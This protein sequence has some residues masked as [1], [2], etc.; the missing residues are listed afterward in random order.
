MKSLDRK[1]FPFFLLIPSLAY[2]WGSNIN[3]VA[4]QTVVVTSATGGAIAT[5]SGGGNAKISSHSGTPRTNSSGTGT[6]DTSRCSTGCF[7]N[8]AVMT[9]TV[10]TSARLGSNITSFSGLYPTSISAIGTVSN[11]IDP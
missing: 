4:T 2:A 6:V 1:V 7:G 8:A 3:S 9:T 5:A 11:I 10:A